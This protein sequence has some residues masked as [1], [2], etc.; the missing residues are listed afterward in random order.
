MV[1]LARLHRHLKGLDLLLLIIYAV[2]LLRL[3]ERNRQSLRLLLE[4]SVAIQ[5]GIMESATDSPYARIFA[6]VSL[7][8]I[9]ARHQVRV[10]LPFLL[11]VL[12]MNM[13]LHP[14][15]L[16]RPHFDHIFLVLLN[17]RQ[18]QLLFNHF[19]FHLLVGV[20]V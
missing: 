14:L 12:A 7:V 11:V 20:A 19:L 17:V 13:T 9:A 8:R 6:F 10:G 5:H 1:G 2:N 15:S 3:L 4:P 16:L 18:R